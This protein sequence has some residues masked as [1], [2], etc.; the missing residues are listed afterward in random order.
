MRF[1][2]MR[3]II[4]NTGCSS[5]TFSTLGISYSLVYYTVKYVEWQWAIRKV[6]LMDLILFMLPQKDHLMVYM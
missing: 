4:L 6:P 1:T 2:F 5:I 3:F